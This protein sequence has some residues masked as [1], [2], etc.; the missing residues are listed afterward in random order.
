M[1]GVCC[2]G[3]ASGCTAVLEE[4]EPSAQSAVSGRYPDYVRAVPR[5]G[6]ERVFVC[7]KPL[8]LGVCDA[9]RLYTG[10]DVA[11]AAGACAGREGQPGGDGG[12]GCL[13][14]RMHGSGA[15][16]DGY[17]LYGCVPGAAVC[18]P[19]SLPERAGWKTGGPGAA[20]GG[21]GA[22]GGQ[23]LH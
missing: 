19:A 22:C 20:G 13:F 16:P 7:D 15:F 4:K 8:V 10:G 1:H 21:A 5:P 12:R 3:A 6:A 23:H 2:P 17:G 11:A 14:C 9:W 18:G